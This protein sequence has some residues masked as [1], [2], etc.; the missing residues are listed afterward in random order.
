MV[1][2]KIDIGLGAYSNGNG[3]AV[4]S[5]RPSGRRASYT[6]SDS[7]QN[8]S[9]AENNGL[10]HG[11]P[12]TSS[13]FYNAADSGDSDLDSSSDIDSDIDVEV[14]EYPVQPTTGDWVHVSEQPSEGYYDD[15]EEVFEVA[16]RSPRGAEG[17]LQVE[18]ETSPPSSPWNG[19]K[20]LATVAAPSSDSF[21]EVGLEDEENYGGYHAVGHSYGGQRKTLEGSL[22]TLNSGNAAAAGKEEDGDA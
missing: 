11:V 18:P 4:P 17:L 1:G 14:A 9:D 13:R 10:G 6:A 8:D 16:P 2:K 5:H 7:E 22:D 19:L 15:D 3:L 12:F 21:D 20:A